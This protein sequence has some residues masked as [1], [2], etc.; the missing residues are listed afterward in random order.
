M[1]KSNSTPFITLLLLAVFCSFSSCSTAQAT[2]QAQT[3][4]VKSKKVLRHVVAFSFKDGVSE[5]EQ[6][7][8]VQRFMD[9]KKEIPQILKFEGGKDMSVEGFNKDLNY[10]FV[11]TFAD[12]AGRDAYLPHPGHARVVKLNKPLMSDLLVIDYWGEE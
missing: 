1:N 10:C 8:A 2:T 7:K 6:A 12:E 11:L 5:E 4:E 9:L 3:S